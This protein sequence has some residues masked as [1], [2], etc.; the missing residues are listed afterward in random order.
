MVLLFTV[1][2]HHPAERRRGTPREGGGAPEGCQGQREAGGPLHPQGSGGD[3]GSLREAA[4]GPAAPA[5]AAAHAAAAE[6]ELPAEPHVVGEAL[7]CFQGAG[8]ASLTHA[9]GVEG[10]SGRRLELHLLRRLSGD[11]IP[12]TLRTPVIHGSAGG[13]R[14]SKRSVALAA[15]C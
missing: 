11:F 14:P 8:A 3:G 5:A 2:L 4:H 13:G 6:P 9:S 15:G 7:R 1:S 12:V 10:G